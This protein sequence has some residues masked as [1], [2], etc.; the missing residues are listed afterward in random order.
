M[1]DE[2][3][4]LTK[5]VVQSSVS[6]VQITE[7]MTRGIIAILLHQRITIAEI[8]II[9]IKGLV[10]LDMLIVIVGVLVKLSLHLS[11]EKTIVHH[12]ITIETNLVPLDTLI[13]IVK[14]TA[15]GDN[16]ILAGKHVWPSRV[17]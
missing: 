14:T 10:P 16:I 13:V 4:G 12:G 2:G 11:S 17:L 6:A 7:S 5:G 3:S 1:I 9:N 8:G 15:V